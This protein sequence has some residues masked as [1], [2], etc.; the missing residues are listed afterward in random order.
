M[1][2]SWKTQPWR[3]EAD[4]TSVGLEAF[5]VDETEFYDFTRLKKVCDGCPVKYQCLDDAIENNDVRF[6][7]RG[8]LSAKGRRNIMEMLSEANEA[9]RKIHG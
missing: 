8:G 1:N 6:G 9:S 3:L 5:Y 4:C 2:F 7:F